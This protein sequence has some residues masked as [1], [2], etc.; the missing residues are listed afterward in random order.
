MPDETFCIEKC[1]NLIEEKLGWG[2]SGRWQTADFENLSSRIFEETQEMISSST[3]KRIWGKVRYDSNPNMATLNVMARFGGFENWRAFVASVPQ[4]VT[5]EFKSPL[6]SRVLKSTIKWLLAASAIVVVGILLLSLYNQRGRTLKP[7][8]VF[9]SSKAVTSGLPNS[10]I[11][12]YDVTKSNA[13]SV[14]IQQDWNPR[15]RFKVSKDSHEYISTYYV[16]G[17]FKAKLLLNDSVIKEHDVFIETDGWV[18]LIETRPVPVYLPKKTYQHQGQFGITEKTLADLQLDYKKTP[19]IFSLSNVS[20]HINLPADNFSFQAI[21]QNTFDDNSSGIC[22]KTF[23]SAIGTEGLINIPLC[24][25]GCIGTI[26]IMLGKQY[27]D[28]KTADL[29]GL[30]VDFD[31]PV[32]FQCHVEEGR[33]KILVNG[34]PAYEA[35]YK[36]NIGRVVGF[37]VTF[38]GTGTLTSF[39][40][41]D[42]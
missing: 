40:W 20:K 23:I 7:G 16:P 11:F 30:G 14:F 31:K 28:G 42:L 29:S 4:Q 17:Y 32:N 19:P 22:R 5:R 21:V 12:Q 6:K 15:L 39:S 1:K 18:G 3:L 35:P 36:Q 37:R 25:K 2:D 26:G 8:Q 10:V 38:F 33:I 34:N 41:K 24:R 13:D 9:F 27:I